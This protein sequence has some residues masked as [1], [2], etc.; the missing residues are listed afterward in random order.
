MKICNIFGAAL[1]GC[2]MALPAAA[3]TV[4]WSS[5]TSA[6]IGSTYTPA[7]SASGS[8]VTTGSGLDLVLALDSS[9]SMT[10][11]TG[12]DVDGDGFND[13]LRKVQRIAARQ[14]VDSLVPNSMVSVGIVDFDSRASVVQPLTTLTGAGPVAV[15]NAINQINASGGTAIDLGVSRAADELSANGTAGRGQQIIV[16]S[17]GESDQSD[18]VSAATAAFAAGY[19]VNA[20]ALPGANT[21]V[22]SAVATAGGGRFIDATNDISKVIGAFSPSGGSTSFVGVQSIMVTDPA[23]NSYA[24]SPDAFGSFSATPYTIMAGANVWRSV[25]TFD[26]GSTLSA[27]LVVNGVPAGGG[28][29]PVPLPG[30]AA[31]YLLGLAVAGAAVRRKAA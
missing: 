2:V 12:A 8:N 22:L 4:D 6:L 21:T 18:A 1:I 20:I 30:G 25:V 19:Q 5:A 14:L 7:G 24:V 23:N 17:D 3:K 13:R 27:E 16:M 31:L 29:A 26:D 10:S 11:L 28:V 15:Q 9:G